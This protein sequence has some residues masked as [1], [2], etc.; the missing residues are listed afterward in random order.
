MKKVKVI[1]EECT[2]HW[3][4]PPFKATKAKTKSI[5]EKLCRI[6][7]ASVDQCNVIS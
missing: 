1:Q 3:A 5:L 4:I 6:Y 2:L 7:T